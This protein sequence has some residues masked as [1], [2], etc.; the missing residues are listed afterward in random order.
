[1]Q[2]ICYFQERVAINAIARIARNPENYA[3]SLENQIDQF[4]IVPHTRTMIGAYPL[5]IDQQSR[6]IPTGANLYLAHRIERHQ[7]RDDTPRL[8]LRN[9]NPS[10]AVW[11]STRSLI[12]I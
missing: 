2:R 10:F 6:N 1:M 3:I 5:T 12:T 7:L 8:K 11:H 4:I 9:R